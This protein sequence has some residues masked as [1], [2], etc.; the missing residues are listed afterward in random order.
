MIDRRDLADRAGKLQDQILKLGNDMLYAYDCGVFGKSDW[1]KFN[2]SLAKASLAI[3]HLALDFA[4]TPPPTNV[5][6]L[7]ARRPVV[8]QGPGEGPQPAA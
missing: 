1:A 4:P 2:S 7:A 3:G 8:R 5:I 6:D